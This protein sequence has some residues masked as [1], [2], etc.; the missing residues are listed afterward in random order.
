M[1]GAGPEDVRQVPRRRLR[2]AGITLAREAGAVAARLAKRMRALGID[3]YEAYLERS[4]RTRPATSCAA[5]RR[6]STN[7]TSFFREPDHFDFLARG[8]DEAA[9][10][11]PAPVPLLVGGVLHG[12]GAVTRSR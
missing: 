2:P 10:R 11:R 1:D 9:G 3:E 12:R 4:R 6:V 5:A 7:V 8:V